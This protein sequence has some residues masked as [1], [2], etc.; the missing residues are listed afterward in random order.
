MG[1]FTGV[2]YEPHPVSPERKAELRDQGLK[3]LDIRFKPEDEGDDADADY[4]KLK[5][6]EIKALLEKRS[7]AFDASA[8]KPE[9]LEL[10]VNSK[11]A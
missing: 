3:I 6:D 5:V 2:A 7:V 8:K 10:L 4:A 1:K 9:L 11:E